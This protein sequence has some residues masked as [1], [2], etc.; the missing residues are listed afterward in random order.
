MSDKIFATLE[1]AKAPADPITEKYGTDGYWKEGEPPPR[2]LIYGSAYIA[3]IAKDMRATDT[4]ISVR[5]AKPTLHRCDI[6][7]AL[8]YVKTGVK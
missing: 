4:A 5:M 6:V 8:E 2:R 3:A 1:D 7:D